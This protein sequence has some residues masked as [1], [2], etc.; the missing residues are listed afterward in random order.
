MSD[1]DDCLV[2]AHH[3]GRRHDA[4]ALFP[5]AAFALWA[6]LGAAEG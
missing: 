2:Y 4:E 1:S 3:F 6:S 5:L